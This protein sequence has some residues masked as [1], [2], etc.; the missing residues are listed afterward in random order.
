MSERQRSTVMFPGMCVFFLAFIS[1]ISR[2]GFLPFEKASSI[3]K[4][5]ISASSLWREEK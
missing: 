2:A 1:S 3:A 4:L 5:F